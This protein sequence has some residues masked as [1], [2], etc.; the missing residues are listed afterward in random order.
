MPDRTEDEGPRAVQQ[1]DGAWLLDGR[2]PLDEFRDLFDLSAVPEGDFQTLAGLVVA[3]L[4]HIPRV[5]EGFDSSGLHLEVV[6][7]DGNRVDRIRVEPLTHR[8][9]QP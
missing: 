7:M 1:A 3:H 9:R 6:E 5:G 4:G 2:I 8:G